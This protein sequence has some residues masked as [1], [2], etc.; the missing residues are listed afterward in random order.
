MTPLSRRPNLRPFRLEGP[1]VATVRCDGV[2]AAAH[3]FGLPA[4]AIHD[5]MHASEAGEPARLWSPERP[6]VVV[7]TFRS[8]FEDWTIQRKAGD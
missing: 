1:G 5:A 2:Q 3:Y 4:E 8:Y 6:G 7:V